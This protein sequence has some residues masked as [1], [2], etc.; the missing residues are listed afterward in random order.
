[1]NWFTKTFVA[2]AASSLLGIASASA[3]SVDF[4]KNG[5]SVSGST[6]QFTGSDGTHIT[7]TAVAGNDAAKIIRSSYG[8]GVDNSCLDDPQIDSLGAN[9]ILWLEFDKPVT[10]K[11]VTFTMVGYNLLDCKSDQY[12]LIIDGQIV[13]QGE[14]P[15]P[16]WCD[17]GEGRVRFCDLGCTTLIGLTAPTWNDDFKVKGLCYSACPAVPLPAA[18]W[19][20]LSGMAMLAVGK[21]RK[22]VSAIQ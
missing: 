4:S 12:A 21:A 17:T 7:A 20:G 3:A 19:M 10:L 15:N 14:I 1:M 6:F 11:C 18:A 13:R 16:N 22:L 5:Q 9:E 2:L 8:L